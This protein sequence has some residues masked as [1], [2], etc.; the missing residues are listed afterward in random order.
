[1][2]KGKIL[3]LLMALVLLALPMTAMAQSVTTDDLTITFSWWGGDSRHEATQAAAEKFTEKYPNIT[4]ETTFGAW[5]GW[6]EATGLKL[7]TDTGEDVMQYNWNWISEFAGTG[8]VLTDLYQYSDVLD[9][10]QFPAAALKASEIDGKLQGIPISTTARTLYWNGNTFAKAG[11]EVPTTFEGLLAAGKTFKDVLG[12][13]YYPLHLGEY[14]RMIFMVYYLESMYNKAWVVDGQLNYS[15]EEIM[16]GLAMI[17]KL[18]DEHVLPLI[19]MVSDYAA[20]PIDQSDRWIDGYWAG[21]YNW[22]TS[23]A[24]VLNALPEDQQPGFVISTMFT[25]L[26]YKGGYN[27]ISMLFVVPESSENP[28]EAAALINFLLNEEEGVKAMASQRGVPA[29]AIGREIASAND[30]V[31]ENTLLA[32]KYALDSGWNTFPLDPTF[33]STAL[34]GTPDGVYAVVFGQ[35]SADMISVEEAADMLIAGINEVLDAAK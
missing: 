4:V 9:T 3:A 34:R 12:D 24:N 11:I 2:T 6:A 16:E 32:T 13:E 27:K 29:S 15:K 28:V 10:T 35:L 22:N 19:S 14:D 23:F 25:D 31:D 18:E 1:M 17:D 30:I 7:A 8:D 21:N 33:E 26:P 5:S 20:D